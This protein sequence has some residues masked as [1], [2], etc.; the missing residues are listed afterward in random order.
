ML[1]RDGFAIIVLGFGY[2]TPKSE[3]MET[4][5]IQL[6]NYNMGKFKQINLLKYSHRKCHFPKKRL[7]ILPF[8]K[9]GGSPETPFSTILLPPWH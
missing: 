4:I 2:C 6:L 7:E 5:T 1:E 8:Q 3:E 9:R